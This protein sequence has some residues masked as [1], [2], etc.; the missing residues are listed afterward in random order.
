MDVDAYLKRI[1]YS[2]PREP[3][4][5]TLRNLQ[6]AHLCNV[7]FENLSIHAAEPIVLDDDAL[8]RKIVDERR[9]GFC[10]EANGLFAAL[11]RAL[12]FKVAMLAA[13]VAKGSDSVDPSHLS[14]VEFG[15]VF[16]HMCLMVELE[17][18]WL[19][20]VGFGDSFVEPLLLDRRD[21]QNQGSERYRIVPVD[22]S[23]VL[24]RRKESETWTAEYRFDLQPHVYAE[25]EEMCR[26]HQTSAE[27]H[28]TKSRICS[29]A[30]KEGRVTLSDMRLITTRG[31]QRHERLV[32]DPGEYAEI[33]RNTFGIVM[34]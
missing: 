26:F 13:G 9:G 32:A 1:N 27:S 23:L 17:E 19:A 24:L 34:K 20:D 25:Y 18:R 6:V 33:L 11:L 22:D 21:D 4:A 29:L 12:G 3:D 15:P 31:Q 30:T 5:K 14:G 28:F 2:G 16:D 10:Y 7:P 8:F